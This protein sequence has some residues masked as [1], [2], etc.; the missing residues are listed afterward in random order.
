MIDKTN[1]SP[2]MGASEESKEGLDMIENLTAKTSDYTPTIAN[3]EAEE[4]V[5]NDK[6][7]K[8]PKPSI[9][10]LGEGL[11]NLPD[12]WRYT[13]CSGKSPFQE[14]WQK[15]PMTKE[16]VLWELENNSKITGFGI[17]TGCPVNGFGIINLDIDSVVGRDWII[18]THGIVKSISSA[19]GKPGRSHNFYYLTPEQRKRLVSFTGKKFEVTD[20]NGEI[21]K[22]AYEIRYKGLF[23]VLPP[24]YHPETGRYEWINSP[25]TTE[26]AECPEWIIEAAEASMHSKAKRTSVDL[27]SEEF[28]ALSPLEQAIYLEKQEQKEA[29][30]EV[31]DWDVL[32]VKDAV[33]WLIDNATDSASINYDEW[34]HLLM[35]LHS[36]DDSD[37]MMCLADTWSRGGSNYT[38]GCVE[39]KW[40]TFKQEG[41]STG[42]V[43][44]GT[45]IDFAKQH[46]YKVPKKH[47]IN[48]DEQ[49]L[50]SQ[51]FKE[52]E[53]PRVQT[54][55]LF[56]G[57]CIG[58]WKDDRNTC[59]LPLNTHK[60]K[61]EDGNNTR[62]V[63]SSISY[64]GVFQDA[65][66]K[67]FF[68]VKFDA[69][70]KLAKILKGST[71]GGYK[72]LLSYTRQKLIT[73]EIFLPTAAFISAKDFKIELSNA[74][75]TNL[76][77][78]LTNSEVN[79][80]FSAL[81]AD[82]LGNGGDEQNLI[83]A[84]GL[85][86][87]GTTYVL[88]PDYQFTADG[89]RTN[90]DKSG[91]VF[92][93]RLAVNAGGDTVP[94]PEIA[95]Y[96]EE[97]LSN[98]WEALK[99]VFGANKYRAL[100]V[101]GSCI[102]SLHYRKITNKSEG[103][104][105]FPVL[106]AYGDAQCGKTTALRAALSLL[107]LHDNGV[108]GNVTTSAIYE[109]AKLKSG[110][111][112]AWDDPKRE[113]M[114]RLEKLT[115]DFFNGDP[116][117]KRDGAQKPNSPLIIAS[118]YTIGDIDPAVSSRLVAVN[119][120]KATFDFQAIDKLQKV[121][122]K[123]SGRLG[124]LIAIGYDK[125]EISKLTELLTIHQP[126][127]R[128]TGNI[129][130][131][132]HYAFKFL[133]LA[134]PSDKAE[135]MAWLCDYC[136]ESKL[137]NEHQSNLAIFFDKCNTLLALGKIGGWN[138]KQSD[139]FLNIELSSVVAAV[140]KEFPTFKVGTKLL[141][142]LLTEQ[143]AVGC[144]SRFF[145]D[146]DSVKNPVTAK[147]TQQKRCLS[148]SLDSALSFGWV[149]MQSLGKDG[150]VSALDPKIA[151]LNKLIG[152]TDDGDTDPLP[153]N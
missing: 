104:G 1:S 67:Q 26:L 30:K 81:T 8:K 53:Y 95:E 36:V 17:I 143:G 7:V 149:G 69:G 39:K 29:N 79:E 107:G 122:K 102:A 96:S 150:G 120:P 133:E 9:R 145:P 112:N 50:S 100:M 97:C 115:R 33:K 41:N 20:S 11:I 40:K 57:N 59:K 44:V 19:S 127:L 113:E 101:V 75:G 45:V 141:T 140:E 125:Q 130:L 118:N 43:G 28:E 61:P 55:L 2:H 23:S 18:S 27:T 90:P 87:D 56:K 138:L 74:I 109:Q 123:A 83:D 73:R 64:E 94:I 152:I 3:S 12:N 21:H 35:A 32:K 71:G 91:W 16:E 24:S 72:V 31:S 34:L 111:P 66:K 22:G 121:S 52:G 51:T 93:D 147:P 124:D 14:E 151:R 92:N 106:S 5:N 116:R 88:N 108:I 63:L 77:C 85:Q 99:V 80:V 25:E 58:I 10:E 78:N 37:E 139:T 49:E 142:Q 132:A 135:F 103:Q 62:W 110:L 146:M 65:W 98:L 129:S 148:L 42:K 46:E 6:F 131:L 114:P 60:D 134:C 4:Q 54:D 117:Y 86:A 153:F 38:A 13:V 48:K 137:Q 136:K 84:V 105:N 82:F 89:I 119:F 128:I 68:D 126:D 15:N 47:E 76:T 70:L 144:R